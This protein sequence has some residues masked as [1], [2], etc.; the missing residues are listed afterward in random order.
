M[1]RITGLEEVRPTVQ[2]KPNLPQRALSDPRF[3]PAKELRKLLG[4]VRR[5][6]ADHRPYGLDQSAARPTLAQPRDEVSREPDVGHLEDENL[7]DLR[8]VGHE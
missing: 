4:S 6:D 8:V 3:N 5:E 2:P 1:K 7:F